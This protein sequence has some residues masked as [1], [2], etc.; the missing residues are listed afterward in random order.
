[1]P[2]EQAGDSTQRLGGTGLGLA[3]SRHL[4]RLMGGDIQL[5]SRPGEGSRFWF[6]IELPTLEAGVLA[7][8]QPKLPTG[9]AGERRRVL[10]ADDVVGNRAMLN[11][12]LAPLGFHIDE[13]ANGQQALERLQRHRPDLVLMDMVMPVMDGLEAIRRIRRMPHCL[14]MPIIAVSANA[15]SSDRSQ[16]LAAGA[17]AFLS[18]PIDREALLDLIAA[19]LGLAWQYG[20]APPPGPQADEVDAEPLLAPPAD[21][22]RVLHTLALTGNMR[23][24]RE[25]AAHLVR[26]DSRYRP[27]GDKLNALAAGYQS[28][29]ILALVK[30]HLGD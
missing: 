22:L 9:Y 6:E 11:D 29:A 2:F 28:K 1:M 13:A 26:L 18:K 8:P 5:E 3:I 15:T 24:L 10:V 23:S 25:R 20:A 30:Q 27:F 19:R 7:L 4:V 21:E 17:N 16:C 14:D 12:L